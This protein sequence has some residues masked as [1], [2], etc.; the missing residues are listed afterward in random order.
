MIQKLQLFPIRKSISQKMVNLPKD[1][2]SYASIYTEPVELCYIKQEEKNSVNQSNGGDKE[3]MNYFN[4][5]DSF[6]S[7]YRNN[8]RGGTAKICLHSKVK[9]NLSN[10]HSSKSLLSS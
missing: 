5:S 4:Q 7:F 6:L 10:E 2:Y 3:N 9:I 1:D 8:K